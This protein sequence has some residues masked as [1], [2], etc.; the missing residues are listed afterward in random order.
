ML[1]QGYA[2]QDRPVINGR[3]ST[4]EEAAIL[5]IEQDIF[6]RAI[7]DVLYEL[8]L[9]KTSAVSYFSSTSKFRTFEESKEMIGS[10]QDR[11]H[12]HAA[13]LLGL[14]HS[15]PAGLRLSVQVSLVLKSDSAA[16]LEIV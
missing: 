13:A 10:E 7:Q 5:L 8:D 12:H 9:P 6:S 14:F 15:E 2:Y 3:S 16:H 1:E 4:G 11:L